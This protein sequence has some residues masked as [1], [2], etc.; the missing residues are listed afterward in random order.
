MT[1]SRSLVE[2]VWPLSPLQEGMLFHAG[3]DDRGPDVYTVQSA[4][5]VNGPVEA[6]RLRTSWEALLTRHAALRACFRP[7][8]GAQMVQ[9]IPR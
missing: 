6:D 2:D 7:V 3:F 4:L 1:R 5:D 9:V 8:T